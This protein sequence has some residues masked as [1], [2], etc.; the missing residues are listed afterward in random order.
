MKALTYVNLP[1][2]NRKVPGDKITAKELKDAGQTDEDVAALK[3]SGAIGD[4][5]DPIDEA[6]VPVEVAVNSVSE[7]N[8]V[9]GE[10][11]GSDESGV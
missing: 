6:H 1:P 7:I 5:D 4:D 2:D 11:G 8:V 3:K 9:T 10:V